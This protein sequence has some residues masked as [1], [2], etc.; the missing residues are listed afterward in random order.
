MGMAA[1]ERERLIAGMKT[2][3]EL[4]K[5]NVV[6]TQEQADAYR[7]YAQRATE[8]KIQTDANKEALSDLNDQQKF[9]ADQG[10]KLFDAWIE[11]GKEL[12]D[13]FK[14]IA[15]AIADAILQAVL[16][17]QGPLA[18][19]FGTK[20]AAGYDIGGLVGGLLG[21]KA[22]A[23]PGAGAVTPAAI[24]A[25]SGSLRFVGGAGGTG[26]FAP[27]V[28]AA[29]GGS[30]QAQAWNFFKSKGLPDFQVASIL[31]H[32]GAESAFNPAVDT[33]DSGNAWGLFQWAGQRRNNMV[34]AVPDWRTNPQGQLQFAWQEMQGPES[35]A[36]NALRSSTSL[37]GG[38]GGFM[39]FERP[40]GFSWGF[41]GTR[42]QLRRPVEDRRPD[43]RQVRGQHR[44]GGRGRRQGYRWSRHVRQR[45]DAVPC[46]ACRTGWRRYRHA[47]QQPVRHAGVGTVARRVGGNKR[48]LRWRSVRHGRG[49][50]WRQCRTVRQWW[51]RREPDLVCHEPGSGLMGEAGPEAVLPLKR[52]TDGKLG[53]AMGGKTGVTINVSN[54]SSA[55]VKTRES[56]DGTTWDVVMEDRLATRLAT[57][58]TPLHK[59]SRIANEG[60]LKRR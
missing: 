17:G 18:G 4:A 25:A 24:Q 6:L 15:N 7:D 10:M 48:R 58:G 38:V 37:R 21:N 59:A 26:N 43:A 9:A 1:D 29:G 31:G 16:F 56:P 5:T 32:M 42:P 40:Q 51:H 3:Q 52:G 34:N 33:G 46:R 11:G 8:A 28:S 39:G 60:R 2:E 12:T 19:F 53:V 36:F 20:P 49:L 50:P 45:L 57:H 47:H 27:T 13:V 30:V 41:S 22:A 23:G 44:N 14:D 35:R 54:Y 55:D